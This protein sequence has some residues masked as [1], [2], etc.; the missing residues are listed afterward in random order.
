MT[1]TQPAVFSSKW[2]F[3]PCDHQTHLQLKEY[4]W[5]LYRAYCQYRRWLTWHN[6]TKRRTGAEPACVERLKVH[7]KNAYEDHYEFARH[8]HP[9]N[10]PNLYAHVLE[11]Y[12]RARRPAAT[13]E[14]VLPLDLPLGWREHL[15]QLRT[16]RA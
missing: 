8:G 15:E 7:I 6:K 16:E 3:H 1:A 13:A 4:H 10:G 11:Q 2:G 14:A 5:V 12:R 9:R